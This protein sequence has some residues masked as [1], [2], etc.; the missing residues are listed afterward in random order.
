M[1]M[2]TKKQAE[3]EFKQLYQNVMKTNDKPL[4]RMCWNDYVD[5]LR[6]SGRISSKSDWTQPSFIK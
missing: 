3:Q 1:G 4:K 6:K 5:G 2:M